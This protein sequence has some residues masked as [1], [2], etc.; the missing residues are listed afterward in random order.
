MET[1][2]PRIYLFICRDKSC[3]GS[4]RLFM[5]GGHCPWCHGPVAPAPKEIVERVQ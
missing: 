5:V 1:S 2:E 4:Q 3:Y